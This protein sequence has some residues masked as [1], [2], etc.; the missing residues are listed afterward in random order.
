MTDGERAGHRKGGGL[1]IRP[2]DG[3]DEVR[4]SA[5]IMV[6]SEPWLTL[7]RTREEATAI[8]TSPTREVYVAVKGGEV[9]GFVILV[10]RGLVVGLV[11]SIAVREDLRGQGIG[12]LL[13]RHIEDR[14][15]REFPNVFLAVSS[16]NTRARKFYERL[17]YEAVGELKDLLIRGETE[18]LMRKSIGPLSE[19][20]PEKRLHAESN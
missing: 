9:A 8:M 11:Q 6:T 7:G 14:V 19:F 13:M 17:G 20:D 18:V 1:E 4:Q 16:Q 12:A 10:M 3:A 15:F 2:I 5:E